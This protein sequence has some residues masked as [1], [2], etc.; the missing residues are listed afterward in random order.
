MYVYICICVYTHI[1]VYLNMCI[2]PG[3]SR[4]KSPLTRR[5]CPVQNRVLIVDLF[6]EPLLKFHPGG[7]LGANGWS[8]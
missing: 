4:S 1:Y 3:R 7:N 5:H 2:C 8:L 6:L